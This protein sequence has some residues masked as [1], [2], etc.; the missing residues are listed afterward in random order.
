MLRFL[1]DRLR[2]GDAPETPAE[3]HA[4]VPDDTLVVAIGDIHGRIDLLT[5]LEDE[6]VRFAA[7]RPERVRRIVCLGDY[8]DRG[9]H[10]KE[11]IDHL[12]AP[13]PDGFERICLLGNHEDYVLRFYESPLEGTG[14]LANGGRETLMSYGVSLP[15]G[16]VTP[17]DM[18]RARTDLLARLPESHVA[19]L[20]S[21]KTHHVEGDYLFVHAGMRPGVS[22]DGQTA[23]DML[24][25]RSPF[26]T[27]DADF[28]HVVVHG[29]TVVEEPE[30]R[31]NRIG[32]D[33]GAYATGRLTGLA[34][35]GDTRTF[36]AS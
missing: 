17:D 6:I 36:L 12:I 20:R 27:S 14:W 13:P 29:H 22:L 1:T 15:P 18:A 11:V 26:L 5:V 16:R 34:L 7:D 24:W 8:I 31:A 3:P 23:E 4:R 33:T 21:L 9:Y 30:L 25:I 2:R 32:I 28:G 19:F 10:S 35:V